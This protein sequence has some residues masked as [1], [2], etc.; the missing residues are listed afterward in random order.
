[1]INLIKKY[2]YVL[3]ILLTATNLTA[4]EV[5]LEMVDAKMVTLAGEKEP[6]I[7]V[8]AGETF[9][10]KTVIKNADRNTG[11]AKINGLE[12]FQVL[13]NSA[14]SNFTMMVNGKITAEN[15]RLYDIRT[16]ADGTYEVGP[17]EVNQNGNI[18]KSNTIKFRVINRPE[19]Y[20]ES[21]E[22]EKDNEN[23]VECQLTADKKN[24]FVG[25]PLVVILKIKCLGQIHNLAFA[26]QITFPGFQ[27]KEDQKPEQRLESKDNKTYQVVEKKFYLIATTAGEHK[28]KPAKIIYQIPQRQKKRS[29]GMFDENFF[30]FGGLFEQAQLIEKN[31]YSNAI[32]IKTLSMSQNQDVTDGVGKFVSFKSSVDKNE[33]LL[34]E[35]IKFTLEIEG[36][37][38]FEQIVTP[39]VE[40]EPFVKSY[41]SKSEFIEDP[42]ARPFTGKKIFEYIIQ[43]NKSGEVIIPAQ[44]FTYLNTETKSIK[45]LESKPITLQINQ[46]V[47]ES[48]VNSAPIQTPTYQT[49]EQET[50]E[51]IAKND[52]E[53]SFIEQDGQLTQTGRWKLPWWLMFLFALLPLIIYTQI[54]RKALSYLFSNKLFSKASKR[55]SLNK[56]ESDFHK[57]KIGNKP[58]QLYSFFLG[59]LALK[60]DMQT[61]E[62]SH[63]KIIVKLKQ[64]GLDENKINDFIDYLNECAS[65]HFITTKTMTGAVVS[66][67]L[68]KRGEY[69]IIVLIK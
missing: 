45:T 51:A 11:D 20:K 43:V 32:S 55:S 64:S 69:W 50:S 8:F 59:L 21:N 6:Q 53:I 63:D 17:A 27:V 42:K 4:T 60:F 2:V 28:I 68:F 14:H 52:A 62:I 29:H 35:A 66:E 18:I 7:T 41:E 13:G 58:E 36:E 15:S 26:E 49:P 38:N 47:G 5:V 61:H 33:A 67:S 3:F 44:K 23:I 34:N 65:L 1:M 25:E 12:K 40:V 22:G 9:K 16:D 39:K 19:N 46:P 24:V 54:L 57:I 37:G 48:T 30:G 56:A 10:L 31:A